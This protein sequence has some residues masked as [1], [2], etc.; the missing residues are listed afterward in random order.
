MAI[1]LL[2]IIVWIFSLTPLA[3]AQRR[4]KEELKAQR[5]PLTELAPPKA[6]LH[7]SKC[8]SSNSFKLNRITGQGSKVSKDRGRLKKKK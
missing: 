3:L 1:G 7:D 8:H 6:R 4:V 5:V 2:F